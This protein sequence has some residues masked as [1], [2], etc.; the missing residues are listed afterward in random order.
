MQRCLPGKDLLE[1]AATIKG[2]E[3]SRLVS[4]LKKQTGIAIARIYF[5][6]KFDKK[7]DEA[8]IKPKLKKEE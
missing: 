2:F 4:K 1:K 6:Q 5:V 3:Y 7:D 8:K